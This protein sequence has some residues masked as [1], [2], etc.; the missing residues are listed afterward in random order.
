MGGKKVL[1]VFADG[2]EEIEAIGVVDILRRAGLFVT[3]AG[4]SGFE[5]TSARG[6]K[7]RADISLDSVK[8]EFDAVVFPGG[9]IGAGNLSKSETV[10]AMIKKMHA[11]GKIVAAI[12]ASPA[13]VLAPTGILDGKNATCYPGMEK[14]FSKKV[15]FQDKPVVVDG[16]VVTSKGPGTAFLF[17]LKI[18]EILKGKDAAE[19]VKREML[20]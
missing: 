5:V 16:N 4:L 2:F 8:E 20:I 14:E 3:I 17:G 7:I 19:T 6:I 12:C 11:Q 1:A 10:N 9:G 13:L 15:K 18:V